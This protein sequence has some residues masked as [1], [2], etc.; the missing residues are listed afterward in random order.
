MKKALSFV[1]AF[2]ATLSLLL[3]A[4]CSLEGKVEYDR[5]TLTK[6]N[7]SEYIAVN[8]YYTDL[9]AQLRSEG[10]EEFAFYDIAAIGH[11]ETSK[12]KDILFEGVS[13]SFSIAFSATAYD[14]LGMGGCDVELDLHGNSHGS[15]RCYASNTNGLVAPPQ[16]TLT[17][18]K[19]T[20]TV[21]VPKEA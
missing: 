6:E 16:P 5:I 15:F 20:G 8:S 7:Y 21:L 1:L 12:R 19:I 13:I 9:Q 11:I 10:T 4:G 17:V 18:T 14:H 2:V 3:L